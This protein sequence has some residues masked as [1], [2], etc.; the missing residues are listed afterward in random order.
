MPAIVIDLKVVDKD[1]LKKI[2][3]L[4][5]AVDELSSSAKDASGDR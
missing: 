5:E 3:R 4:T 1:A 2:E